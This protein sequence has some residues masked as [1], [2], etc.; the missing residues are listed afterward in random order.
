M[1]NGSETRRYLPDFI[2]LVDDGHEDDAPLR[3]VVEIKDC[4]DAREKEATMG[5][6]WVPALNNLRALG[7]WAFAELTEIDQIEADFE[8]K[9]ESA[10]DEM[11][12]RAG[13]ESPALFA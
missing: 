10:F 3:L 1:D 9:V 11:I 8:A 12:I 2:V 4:A 13:G 7:R 5:T 6:Y